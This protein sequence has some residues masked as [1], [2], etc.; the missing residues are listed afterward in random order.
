M[1]RLGIR[2]VVLA[3]VFTIAGLISLFTVSSDEVITFNNQMIDINDSV[4]LQFGEFVQEMELYYAGESVDIP[5]LEME[6]T[7]LMQQL[8]TGQTQLAELT[9]PDCDECRDFHAALVAYNENSYKI[10]EA[11]DDIIDYVKE[12][13]PPTD[14]DLDYIDNALEELI[15]QDEILFEQVIEQQDI[16]ANKFDITIE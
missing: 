13:N 3:V 4:E 5:T 14:A 2:L 16:I 7:E 1:R 6:H 8:E 11:Y 10:G 15:Q 9:V 12:H